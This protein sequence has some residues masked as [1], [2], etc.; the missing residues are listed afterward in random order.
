MF[1][2]LAIPSII[3]VGQSR[4][5][6]LWFLMIG[7]VLVNVGLLI[8]SVAKDYDELDNARRRGRAGTGEAVWG[9]VYV[10]H[11]GS[12]GATRRPIRAR[13]DSGV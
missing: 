5:R 7:I 1:L 8:A 2:A 13:G 9:Q 6:L 3:L 10:I 4:P 12:S 11:Y